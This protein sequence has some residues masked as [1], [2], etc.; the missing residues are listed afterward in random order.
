[1]KQLGDILTTNIQNS[2]R[3]YIAESIIP[4]T[5]L[6]SHVWNIRSSVVEDV[7]NEIVLSMDAYY[8]A[9][10]QLERVNWISI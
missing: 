7:C 5:D 9:I 2:S 10:A 4:G 6:F 8:R 3:N 1:M